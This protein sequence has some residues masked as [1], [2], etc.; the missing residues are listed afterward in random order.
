[1]DDQ[2]L[3]FGDSVPTGERTTAAPWPERVATNGT[4]NYH[5]EMGTTL[6]DLVATADATVD[7]HGGDDLT[8]LVHAGHNDAQ[9]RHG[10]PRV[11]L[12]RFREAAAALDETLADH[13]GVAVHGFVGL[14]PLLGLDRPDSVSF[15]DEQ[16]A[17]SLAYDDA[18]AE[19][20]ADHVTVARPVDEWRARTVDGVH[21][22]DDGHAF[23]AQLV[24]EWLDGA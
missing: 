23:V 9:L 14:V 21:P 20:V 18:L 8:V 2:W 17:R 13:P 11:P 1:M 6:T 24:R 3:V 10:D 4:V 5:G 19:T 7:A 12:D 16:P 15:S 22:D